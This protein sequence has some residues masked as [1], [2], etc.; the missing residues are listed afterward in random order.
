MPWEWLYSKTSNVWLSCLIRAG[1]VVPEGNARAELLTHVDA[2]LC[3][4]RRHSLLIL[5]AL[6]CFHTIHY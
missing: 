6:V 2:S 1:N 3:S 5:P 4:L